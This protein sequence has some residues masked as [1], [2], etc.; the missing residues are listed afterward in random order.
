MV[1]MPV[2]ALEGLRRAPITELKA[3]LQ[4]LRAMNSTLPSNCEG[5]EAR[6]GEASPSLE[7]NNVSLEH[8]YE[9]E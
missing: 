1:S 8:P 4:L 9:L 2:G 7:A 6:S 3:M 5:P